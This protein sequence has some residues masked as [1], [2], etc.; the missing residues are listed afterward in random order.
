[1]SSQSI[2]LSEVSSPKCIGLFAENIPAQKLFRPDKGTLFETL[3]SN[4]PHFWAWA[5][6]NARQFFTDSELV[7]GAVVGDPHF[8]NF[9]FSFISGKFRFA[10]QDIDDAG[11]GPL[12]LDI[13]RF[14]IG[15]KM[16]TKDIKIKDLMAEYLDGLEGKNSEVP[17]SMLKMLE[18]YPNPPDFD[19]DAF[20]ELPTLGRSTAQIRR[21]FEKVKADFMESRNI[22]EILD[23]RVREKSGG[24][25]Q[26]MIRFW[27]K[28][29]V[30]GAEKLFE[31]KQLAN[32]ASKQWE[33]QL[34][35]SRDEAIQ[36]GQFRPAADDENVLVETASGFYLS[37]PRYDIPGLA[38]DLM[39]EKPDS[40][41]AHERLLYIAYWMG[42]SQSTQSGGKNLARQF[43]TDAKALTEK[44]KAF[45][46]AYEAE[47]E[48]LHGG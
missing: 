35:Y 34:D 11:S 7:E 26:G 13:A 24:G 40:S 48:R 47:L 3:R 20:K 22:D 38:R 28:C 8:L 1:V 9:G 18:K 15:A 31:F 2:A 29:K 42:K 37:R 17:D 4:P 33:A 27:V 23:V 16:M 30:R 10:V 39:E 14:I 45:R 36:K 21:T 5:R 32:P 19:L 25:S 43:K 46:D 6:E 44:I 12:I 41:D